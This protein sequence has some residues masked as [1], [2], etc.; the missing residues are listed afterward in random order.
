[1]S[2]GINDEK[3]RVYLIDGEEYV[4]VYDD[5]ERPMEGYS[6]GLPLANG[7]IEVVSSTGR[8]TPHNSYLSVAKH[9]GLLVR[10][11][12]EEEKRWKNNQ[13]AKRYVTG[14]VVYTIEFDGEGSRDEDHS[15]G[16]R[17][18][19]KGI[20]DRDGDW[21]KIRRIN[22]TRPSHKPIIGNNSY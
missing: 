3:A 1:M 21:E 10:H 4:F 15:S 16:I 19:W 17:C 18:H 14:K 13:F 22:V 20:Y 2:Y 6:T 5:E 12:M 9:L 11:V 8:R 7:L